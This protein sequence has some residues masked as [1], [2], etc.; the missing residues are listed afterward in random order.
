LID[1]EIAMTFVIEKVPELV[2]EKYGMRE[3]N[4]KLQAG[5]FDYEWVIDRERDVFLRHVRRGDRDRPQ[6][7]YFSL[8]W[9][10]TLISICLEKHGEGTR[11]GK[12]STTWS[13]ADGKIPEQLT[14]RRQEILA[15]LK[16]ALVAYKDFGSYSTIADHTAHF[17][18]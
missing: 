18:F 17:K 9:K 11:G 8:Y 16:E 7:H 10:G 3:I 6:L 14:S 5:D 4:K 1:E 12:G 15:D 13:W 2:I